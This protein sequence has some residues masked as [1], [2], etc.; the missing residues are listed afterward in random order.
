MVETALKDLWTPAGILLGFQLSVLKWRFERETKVG[1]E[2]DIPWLIPADYVGLAAVA[3]FV[4]G[5]YLLPIGGLIG[6]G[7]ARAALGL[8]AL[9]FAGHFL[10]LCGHYQLFNRSRVRQFVWFPLQEKL[11]V[12]ATLLVAVCYVAI[13]VHGSR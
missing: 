1:D 13:V 6:D 2:G 3:V 12:G 8:G 10:G 9:L 4:F 11:A 7:A 5:V